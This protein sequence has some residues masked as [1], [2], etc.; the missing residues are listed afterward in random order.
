M[1]G[2]MKF[3][4]DFKSQWHLFEFHSKQKFKKLNVI[5]CISVMPDIYSVSLEDQH[6][7]HLYNTYQPISS[8]YPT[9]TTVQLVIISGEYWMKAIFWTNSEISIFISV[10]S[11]YFNTTTKDVVLQ[12]V[13]KIRLSLHISLMRKHHNN[14]S[15]WQ[16]PNKVWLR[17]S[18]S[19]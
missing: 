7:T 18:C 13:M 15:C 11:Y 8:Y 14:D 4:G 6:F 1:K 9:L 16:M 19:F 5:W 2:Q 12:L 17:N 3:V 10:V